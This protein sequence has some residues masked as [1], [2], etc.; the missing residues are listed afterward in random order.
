MAG[1]SSVKIWRILFSI[2][3]IDILSEALLKIIQVLF[4]ENFY[5]HGT[6]PVVTEKLPPI[7]QGPVKSCALWKHY[8]KSDPELTPLPRPRYEKGGEG[9]EQS[10]CPFSFGHV[11]CPEWG[12]GEVCLKWQQRSRTLWVSL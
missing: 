12:I 5:I 2:I 4:S 8:S 10:R 3:L 7:P 9:Q 6:P 1:S 11:P